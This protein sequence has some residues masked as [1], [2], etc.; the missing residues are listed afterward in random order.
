[1]KSD[2]KMQED[3]TQRMVSFVL[4]LPEGLNKKVV[5]RAKEGGMSK[6]MYCRIALGKAVL[7]ETF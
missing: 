5:A 3:T 4:P 2:P 1:M 7:K 6:K